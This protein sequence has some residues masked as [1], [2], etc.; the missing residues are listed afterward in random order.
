MVGLDDLSGLSNFNDSLIFLSF[1]TIPF[2]L[3]KTSKQ[4]QVK[5]LKEEITERGE[6][7]TSNLRLFFVIISRWITLKA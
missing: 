2:K 1:K 5:K 3:Y 7:P 4:K 6:H